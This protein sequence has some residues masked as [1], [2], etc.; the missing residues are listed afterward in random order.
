MLSE[1]L[2]TFASRPR[3]CPRRP[4]FRPHTVPT[5]VV[6]IVRHHR[7]HL[8]DST[9]FYSLVI[10][11]STQPSD[12]PNAPLHQPTYGSSDALRLDEELSVITGTPLHDQWQ[13]QTSAKLCQPPPH[14]P[15]H[16]HPPHPPHQFSASHWD[17]MMQAPP[18]PPHSRLLLRPSPPPLL[19]IP[20][21]CLTQTLPSSA[22]HPL[23]HLI[24][25][26][27]HD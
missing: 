16:Q 18:L 4:G 10:P 2:F 3:C 5:T 9:V 8:P 13:Y 1:A 15:L 19:H 17:L 14:L 11:L 22:A 20:R 21:A 26:R 24:V 27:Y 7:H 23:A 6:S 12:L 25:P